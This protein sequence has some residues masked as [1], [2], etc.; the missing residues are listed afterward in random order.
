MDAGVAA[1]MLTAGVGGGMKI[2]VAGVAGICTAGVGGGIAIPAAGVGGGRDDPAGVGGG[3][4]LAGVGAG[5]IAVAGV[6][7]GSMLGTVGG[8]IIA[9]DPPACIGSTRLDTHQEVTCSTRHQFSEILL[10][11]L[12]VV[13]PAAC[14]M[15]PVAPQLHQAAP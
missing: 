5:I 2:P 9:E 6:G 3:G 8:G 4:A 11:M 14:G 10:C 15:A 1:G 7:G 13:I 12:E